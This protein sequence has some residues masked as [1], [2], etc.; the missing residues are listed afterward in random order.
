MLYDLLILIFYISTF[1]IVLGIAGFIA[2]NSKW[3]DKIIK[4]MED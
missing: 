2:D 4:Y 1:S 3:L